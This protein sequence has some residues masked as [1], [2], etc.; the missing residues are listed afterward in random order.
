MNDFDKRETD[1]GGE[2]VLEGRL[3]IE[4]AERIRGR[5]I[6]ALDKSDHVVVDLG[7]DIEVDLSFLQLLCSAHYTAAAANKTFRLKKAPSGIFRRV[8]REAG[9]LR[10]T[11]CS[12]DRKKTCLWAMEGANE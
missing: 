7:V 11:G 4:N 1:M 8:I 9:Y 10:K 5:L 12:R 6:D 2:L 3:T